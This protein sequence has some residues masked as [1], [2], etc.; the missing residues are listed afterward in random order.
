MDLSGVKQRQ[1]QKEDIVL[2]AKNF[3][4]AYKKEIGESVRKEEGI[5][6]L[7]FNK[8][9][10]FSTILADNILDL[11]EETIALLEIALEESEFLSEKKPR[12][13]VTELPK[14]CFLPIRAIRAKH[15]DKILTVEGIIRQ[16]SEVRPQVVNARF[17]CPNCGA[18]LSV[19]QIERKFQDP[20]RCSCGWKGNFKLLSK[21]MVDAQRLVIE[22]SPD[23]LE[24]GEQ[25]RRINVFLKEEWKSAQ[26]LEAE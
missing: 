24:G 20:S 17:E 23:T 1:K 21:E 12:V 2:E 11:P 26:L 5:V 8:L 10:E 9:Q 13:R 18:I 7:D 25:P 19:L 15:L 22:E 14:S 3:F 16:A 6:K 4:N